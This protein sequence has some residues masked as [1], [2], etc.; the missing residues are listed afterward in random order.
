VLILCYLA[1][2]LVMHAST[3]CACV[4]FAA[5]DDTSYYVHH[6]NGAQIAVLTGT[7]IGAALIVVVGF[8]VF[9]IVMTKLEGVTSFFD[10]MP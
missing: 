3:K 4:L 5:K 2:K 10:H 7:F 8:V 6:V 9:S 1:E